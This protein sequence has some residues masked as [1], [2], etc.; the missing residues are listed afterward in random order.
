MELNSCL[1]E[2]NI[3][4]CRIRP[5]RHQYTNKIL[6]HFENKI[7]VNNGIRNIT[8]KDKKVCLRDR[9]GKEHSFDKVIVAAHADQAIEMLGD[10]FEE[11]KE[12]LSHFPYQKNRC[13]LPAYR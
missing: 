9:R 10:Q 7:H 4:H 1:Y 3:M 6:S 11:E 5:K 2:V 12:L 8:L 13:C